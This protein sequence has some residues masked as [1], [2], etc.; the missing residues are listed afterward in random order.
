[1][2]ANDLRLGSTAG[3][4]SAFMP[5]S[6]AASITGG[7][8]QPTSSGSGTWPPKSA[9]LSSSKPVISAFCTRNAMGSSSGD[10][11]VLP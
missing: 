8:C 5:N 1:M 9:S 3:Q 10:L 4:V 11:R 7:L 6:S 2:W